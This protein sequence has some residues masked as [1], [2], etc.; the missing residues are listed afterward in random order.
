MLCFVFVSVSAENENAI[1]GA[2]FVFGRKRVNQSVLVCVYLQGCS[3]NSCYSVPTMTT[4]DLALWS[5]DLDT[6]VVVEFPR[7]SLRFIEK[8]GEGPHGEVDYRLGSTIAK[9][10]YNQP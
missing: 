4:V 2:S 7:D 3:G 8:L 1:F 5:R 6:P 10:C 9:A